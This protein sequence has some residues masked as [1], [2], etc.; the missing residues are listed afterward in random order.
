MEEMKAVGEDVESIH[1]WI[2]PF[3]ERLEELGLAAQIPAILV[4]VILC[5]VF[6]CMEGWSTRSV[7]ATAVSVMIVGYV[8]KVYISNQSLVIEGIWQAE[9]GVFSSACAVLGVTCT[10]PWPIVLYWKSTL[11]ASLVNL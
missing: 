3:S 11:P 8:G 4:T 10:Y 7:L 2:L 9:V 1:P 6:V 5:I